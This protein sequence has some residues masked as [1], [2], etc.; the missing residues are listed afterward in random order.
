MKRQALVIGINEYLNLNDLKSAAND[1]DAIAT[2]LE[3]QRN[4]NV[5]RIPSYKDANNRIRVHPKPCRVGSLPTIKY[6]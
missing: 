3:E 5:K 2:I 4:F 6:L 1:A